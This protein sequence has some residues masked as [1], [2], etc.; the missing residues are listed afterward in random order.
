MFG[1]KTDSCSKIHNG[2][3]S[4]KLCSLKGILHNVYQYF[5]NKLLN[6]FWILSFRAEG[7]PK[8]QY[9]KEI[10]KLVQEIVIWVSQTEIWNQIS[11]F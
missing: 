6:F 4:T 3:V 11:G 10:A 1:I 8:R 5:Q 2:L 9:P 7:V